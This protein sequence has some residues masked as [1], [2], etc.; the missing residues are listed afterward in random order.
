MNDAER[1]RSARRRDAKKDAAR[2]EGCPSALN[3]WSRQFCRA[4]LNKRRD[5]LARHRGYQSTRI[6]KLKRLEA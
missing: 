3:G 5:Y 4:C 6:S 2:C 1:E